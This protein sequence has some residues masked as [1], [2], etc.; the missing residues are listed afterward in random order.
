MKR[1]M[2]VG[3]MLASMSIGTI[4]QAVEHTVLILPDAYFPRITYLNP[5]DTVRFIN[6]TDATHEIVS[7]NGTWTLEIATEGEEVMVIEQG[8]QKTFYDA[9]SANVDDEGNEYFAVEGKMSFS[10]PPID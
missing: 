3:A 1:T 4:A 7:K 10:P 9:E 2:F 8:V 6:E 5:G